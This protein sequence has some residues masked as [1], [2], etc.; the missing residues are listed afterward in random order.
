MGVKI[1]IDDIRT[2]PDDTW[3]VAK[4]YDE[5]CKLI[6]ENDGDIEMISFDNDLGDPWAKEGR[7]VFDYLDQGIREGW[8]TPVSNP[9]I[10]LLVHTD[11]SSAREY[12]T[13]GIAALQDYL[14]N[15]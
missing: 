6:E 12:M 4:N 10:N 7:H 3:I 2:P 11:N 15:Q 8:L 9:Q 5:A 13:R 1:Y 14:L